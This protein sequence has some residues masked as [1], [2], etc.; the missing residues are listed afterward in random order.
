M[1]TVCK[2]GHRLNDETRMRRLVNGK[3]KYQGCKVCS[4][5][6]SKKW[7]HDNQEREALKG[8]TRYLQNREQILA[9]MQE[10]KCLK[11]Y[12]ITLQERRRLL[13]EQGHKCANPG[14]GRTVVKG[15]L[16]HNHETGAVRGILCS[17]CNMVLG[18]VQ[19]NI[20]RLL[21]LTQYLQKHDLS[22]L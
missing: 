13:E 11:K 19:E 10:D 21:G 2:R 7:Y 18:L 16:D 3:W 4:Q 17:Q 20:D 12:G 9:K 1:K 6:R 15:H 8:K 22:G 5:E 14:C